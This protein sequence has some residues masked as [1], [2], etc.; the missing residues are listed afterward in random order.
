L[1]KVI[2]II[3]AILTVLIGIAL[4]ALV[5]GYEWPLVMPNLTALPQLAPAITGSTPALKEP[6]PTAQS[7]NLR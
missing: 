6:S 7:A 2:D 5:G 1:G 4:A 3:V